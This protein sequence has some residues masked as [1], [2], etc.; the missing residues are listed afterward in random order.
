MEGTF[1]VC[2]SQRG[3]VAE[4]KD[5]LVHAD[6]NGSSFAVWMVDD[7]GRCKSVRRALLA[8]AVVVPV[9]RDSIFPMETTFNE[10]QRYNPFLLLE[11]QGRSDEMQSSC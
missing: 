7:D 9:V 3:V 6:A 11:W 4:T 5:R 2:F 1:M 10:S 8:M